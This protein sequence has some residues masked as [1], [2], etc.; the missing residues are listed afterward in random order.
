MLKRKPSKHVV[1]EDGIVYQLVPVADALPN[2]GVLARTGRAIMFVVKAV[3]WVTITLV[4]IGLM[5]IK[6]R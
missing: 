4:T 1:G 5:T 3:G 2:P 6:K